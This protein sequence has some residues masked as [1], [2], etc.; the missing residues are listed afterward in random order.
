VADENATVRDGGVNSVD[1]DLVVDGACVDG[2]DANCEAATA[3]ACSASR[4]RIH[5]ACMRASDAAENVGAVATAGD[6]CMPLISNDSVG[7]GVGNGV[8][9]PLVSR[10]GVDNDEDDRS[11]V[12]YSHSS[13]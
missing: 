8:L 1:D 11:G 4:R 10:S 6:L 2:K 3:R 13:H 9:E 12:T 5:K 7:V